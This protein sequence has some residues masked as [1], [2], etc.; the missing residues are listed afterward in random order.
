[1]ISAQRFTFQCRHLFSSSNTTT[2]AINNNNNNTVSSARGVA[3]ILEARLK[4]YYFLIEPKTADKHAIDAISRTITDSHP[5]VQLFTDPC[6]PSY[7]SVKW[8]FRPISHLQVSADKVIPPGTLASW[9]LECG[10]SGHY[11][12]PPSS[13][14]LT[15]TAT[16]D[17]RQHIIFRCL[18]GRLEYLRREISLRSH[19]GHRPQIDGQIDG[20]EPK[21]DIYGSA[22]VWQSIEDDHVYG[23]QASRLLRDLQSHKDIRAV[24]HNILII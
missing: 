5:Q 10:A 7:G 18:R 11:F 3:S 14:S 8:M 22:E 2:S 24:Y 12:P 6:S 4:T 19:Y 16:E 23:K 20:W 17:Q 21:D 15:S 9:G 1:M 13:L